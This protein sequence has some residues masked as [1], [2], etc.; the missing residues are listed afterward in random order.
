MLHF[1]LPQK[2]FEGAVVWESQDLHGLV[3]RDVGRVAVH[4][5]GGV[6]RVTSVSRAWGQGCPA[7]PLGIFNA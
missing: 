6:L 3:S 7:A 2:S 1:S 5:G 4:D